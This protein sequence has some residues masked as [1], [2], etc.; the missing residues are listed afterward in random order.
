MWHPLQ[1][2]WKPLHHHQKDQLL[3]N[4]KSLSA[5][6]PS[7]HNLYPRVRLFNFGRHQLFSFNHNQFSI[8][9]H[10][11]L[12][13]SQHVLL[14][15]LWNSQTQAQKTKFLL[16]LSRTWQPSRK[17]HYPKISAI[18]LLPKDFTAEFLLIGLQ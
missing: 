2:T 13:E 3:G 18:I 5:P 16:A 15:N 6:K 10:I 1:T 8:P 14:D 7:A 12:D 17:N 9:Q 11:N 4:R